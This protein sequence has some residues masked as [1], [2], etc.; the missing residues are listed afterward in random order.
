[1]S[2]YLPQSCAFLT[3][4]S[5]FDET[6]SEEVIAMTQ[7]ISKF[8]NKNRYSLLLVCKTWFGENTGTD[9]WCNV[10]S[11]RQYYNMN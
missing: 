9:P 3:M 1:M 8:T 2:T 5:T 7:G 4:P 10:T 11:R 6:Q